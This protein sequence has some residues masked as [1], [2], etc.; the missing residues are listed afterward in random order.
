LKFFAV[1][2]R[3]ASD[4]TTVTLGEVGLENSS[5]FFP[6]VKDLVDYCEPDCSPS[7]ILLNAFSPGTNIREAIAALKGNQNFASVPIVLMLGANSEKEYLRAFHLEVYG[8]IVKPL[9]AKVLKRVIKKR[10]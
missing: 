4:C 9:D 1:F 7:L 10:Q 2:Y 3:I 8:Y 5:H 6:N